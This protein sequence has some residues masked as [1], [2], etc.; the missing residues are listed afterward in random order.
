M[1]LTRDQILAVDDLPRETVAVPE[2]GGE[3]IIRGLTGRER[4]AYEQ[5]L[6]RGRGVVDYD[7]ARAKLLVRCIID[8]SG[9][10]VFTEDDADALGRKAGAVLDRLFS[11]AAR[12]SG[13]GPGD[14]EELMGNSGRGGGGGLRSPSRASSE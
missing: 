5:S 11:V 14:V 3:L 1:S 6:I 8:E 7:N 10:R 9:E 12:L 4:D 2:W 13:L